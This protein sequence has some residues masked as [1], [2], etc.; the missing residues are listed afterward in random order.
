MGALILYVEDN[1]ENRL[2]VR[3]ILEAE[4]YQVVEAEDGPRGLELARSMRPDL[5]LVD[6]HLPD[7]DGYELV[8]RF[9]RM[10]HLEGIPIVALTADVIRGTRERALATGCDGYIPKPID[11]DALPEQIAAFLKDREAPHGR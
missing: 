4:G 3:R 9:K 10:S 2:L 11:V 7:I 8:R 5:I 1:L 6:L